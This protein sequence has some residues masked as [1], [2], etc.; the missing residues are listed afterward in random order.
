MAELIDGNPLFPGDNE[1][2]QLYKI[3]KCLGELT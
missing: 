1:I 3:Q 2:D